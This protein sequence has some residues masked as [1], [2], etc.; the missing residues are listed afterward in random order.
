MVTCQA[1]KKLPQMGDKVEIHVYCNP[2]FLILVLL[3]FLIRVFYL[4]Y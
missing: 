3:T 2:F 1:V 4:N